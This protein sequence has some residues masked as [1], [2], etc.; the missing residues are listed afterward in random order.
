[1]ALSPQRFGD[2]A[3]DRGVVFDEQE[4]HGVLSPFGKK[5]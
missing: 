2:G 4:V 1:V 3:S 5:Q